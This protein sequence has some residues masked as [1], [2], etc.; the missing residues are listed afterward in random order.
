MKKLEN[1]PKKEIFSVPDGYFDTLPGKIQARISKETPAREQGFVFRYK[2]QY[3]LPVVVLLAAGI[4]WFASSN[5]TNDPETLLASVQT[6]ALMAY[7]SESDLTT[8]DILETI[9][10]NTSDLDAIESEVYELNL[11]ALPL[12]DGIDDDINPEDI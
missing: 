6:E 4:Y 11:D 12:E 10:F 1:I 7:L 5:Q 9:D 2:L 8:E 3:V